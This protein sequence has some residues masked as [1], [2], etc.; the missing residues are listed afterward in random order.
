MKPPFFSSGFLHKFSASLKKTRKVV[1]SDHATTQ[2]LGD[3]CLQLWLIY[4][5]IVKSPHLKQEEAKEVEEVEDEVELETVEEPEEV[6]D[7]N[8]V[9][10]T[11]ETPEV[12]WAI[13]RQ[14][15]SGQIIMA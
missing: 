15:S 3:P 14:I 1:T 9:E 12:P 11:D 8:E 7:S 13:E 10:R 6:T 2:W 5:Q 4:T